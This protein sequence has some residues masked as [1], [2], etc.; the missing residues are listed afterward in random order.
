MINYTGALGT[1]NNPKNGYQRVVEDRD[2]VKHL[3]VFFNGRWIHDYRCREFTN[4]ECKR[5]K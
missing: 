5:I 4:K 3:E 2:G 1:L